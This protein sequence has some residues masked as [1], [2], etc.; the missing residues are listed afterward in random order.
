QSARVRKGAREALATGDLHGVPAIIVEGRADDILPPNFVDRAYVG[1]N[2]Q[3]ERGRS[4]LRYYEVK[5]ANHLDNILALAGFD[6]TL[7]PLMK[8]YI[9]AM[10]IVYAHLRHGDALPPS[11]VV[12]TVPR[13]GAPGKAPAI[14]LDNVPPIR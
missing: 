12:R 14:T 13:G 1:L 9:E 4:R 7:V 3:T 8:Y 6:T 10:N 2:A 11:Q 5:N